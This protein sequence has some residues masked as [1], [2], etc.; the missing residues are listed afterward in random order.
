MTDAPAVLA[1][2]R[3]PIL[4][5]TINRPEAR[6]AVNA[7]VHAGL[8]EGLERAEADPEIRVV[9][10]TGAGDQAFCAGADLKALSRGERLEPEDKAQR[11]WGFAGFVRHP[12][13]KPIIAA[14]N[15]FALGGGTELALASDLVIAADHAQFGLPEVKRGIIAA[16]GGAFRIVQQLPQK[17]AMQLLL[18][19]EPISA[20]RALDLGL[21]NEVVPLGR[22]MDTALDYAE[23][24][25]V[26]APLAVQASKRIAMGIT[27][28]RIASDDDYWEAN[29]RETRTVFASEDSREG[30]RAFAE[31]RPPVWQAR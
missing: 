31:K 28:G 30:P 15:G 27:E 29:K 6:N 20:Q 1:E 12:I 5:L 10:V 19:G 2:R 16:A 22:L 21:A 14:V 11:A 24:I 4:I 18:T 9:I 25:A 7:A 26:N 13:G 17:V 23:R 8:G 3:G